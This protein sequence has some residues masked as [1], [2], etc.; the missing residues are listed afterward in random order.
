MIEID[1]ILQLLRELKEEALDSVRSPTGRD[2][3]AFGAAHGQIRAMD[4]FQ[5]RF[6]ALIQTRFEKEQEEL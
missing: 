6:E 5:A 2:A 4:E 3:F 1:E